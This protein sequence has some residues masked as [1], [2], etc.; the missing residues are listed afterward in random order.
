MA[1]SDKKLELLK[2]R[3]ETDLNVEGEDVENL[4]KYNISNKP[5]NNQLSL[6]Q[7]VLKKNNKE[8]LLIELKEIYEVYI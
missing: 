8:Q 2:K 7:I 1:N 3:I 5:K 6:I 4:F